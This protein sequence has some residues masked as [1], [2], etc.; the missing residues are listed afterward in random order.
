MGVRYDGGM[1]YKNAGSTDLKVI[2]I[3]LEEN[4][5]SC[6]TNGRLNLKLEVGTDTIHPLTRYCNVCGFVKDVS[7]GKQVRT[8]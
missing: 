7:H 8:A 1:P 3:E 2:D 6:G 4:C 5:P